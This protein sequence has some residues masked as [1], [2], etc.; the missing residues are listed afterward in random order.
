MSRETQIFH[1]FRVLRLRMLLYRQDEVVALEEQ[2]M[3]VEDDN[4]DSNDLHRGNWRLDQNKKRKSLFKQLDRKMAA[5]G[6]YETP[7][8]LDSSNNISSSTMVD[9][10]LDRSQRTVSYLAAKERAIRKLPKVE[11]KE[12]RHW[13][14]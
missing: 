9:D 6:T 14:N 10:L 4:E 5:Y 1:R 2:L 11:P 7:F 3:E 12:P 13:R 8:L